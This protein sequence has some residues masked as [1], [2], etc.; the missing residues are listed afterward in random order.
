MRSTPA[1][2]P[3]TLVVSA[4][5][6]GGSEAS[7]GS[8]TGSGGAASRGMGLAGGAGGTGGMVEGPGTA[9]LTRPGVHARG[10]SHRWT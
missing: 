1:L 9:S 4:G 5:A 8:T 3:L 6:C 10:S 2:L 7:A